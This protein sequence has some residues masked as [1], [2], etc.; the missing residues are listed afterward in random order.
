MDGSSFRQYGID[1]ALCRLDFVSAAEGDKYARVI[2]ET[3][4]A[5]RK[6][7]PLQR[8]PVGD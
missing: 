2:A 7:G 5:V 4:E 6:L 3:V 8:I 1:E